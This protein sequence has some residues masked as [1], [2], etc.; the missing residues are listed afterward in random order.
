MREFP[1]EHEFRKGVLWYPEPVEKISGDILEIGPGRGDLCMSLADRYPDKR[2]TAVEL[3]TRRY[4][5]LA[6]RIE[7]QELTNL[8]VLRTAAQ[9]A[10]PR[11]CVPESFERVYVL[12]PDP[13]PKKRHA[14]NRLLSPEFLTLLAGLLKP[15]GSFFHATDYPEYVQWVLENLNQVP[16]L[17]NE[18]DPYMSQADI[19]DYFP[20]FFEELWRTKGRKIHYVRCRRI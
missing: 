11:Y 10:I 1:V 12:F 17:Q 5:K 15:G 2:I 8:T 6:K 4:Y 20:S 14:P 16:M 7:R 9:V 19:T 13:W 18:G 3:S